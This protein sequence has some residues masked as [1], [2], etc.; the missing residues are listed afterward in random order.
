MESLPVT[1]KGLTK[2]DQI[3]HR[4]VVTKCCYSI[5]QENGSSNAALT[6]EKY[7]KI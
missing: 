7:S 4:D 6:A 3:N 1:I 5:I 2:L